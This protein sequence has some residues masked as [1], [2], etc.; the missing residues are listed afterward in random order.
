MIPLIVKC[1]IVADMAQTVLQVSGLRHDPEHA[2][3]QGF[4]QTAILRGVSIIPRFIAPQAVILC[5]ARQINDLFY[6]IALI[7][8]VELKVLMCFYL[9][10]RFS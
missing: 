8:L 3:V 2:D 1:T 7:Y 6:L 9:E 10:N 4:Q 5:F